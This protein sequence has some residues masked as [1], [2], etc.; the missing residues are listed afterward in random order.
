MIKKVK[1]LLFDLDGVLVTTERNHFE[2]WKSIADELSIPFDEY[3]NEQ[4]KGVSRVDSLKKILA[5]GSIE[6]TNSEFNRLLTQKNERYLLSISDLN[7]ENILPGV[8]PLLQNAKKHSVKLGVGSSSKNARFILEKLN[9]IHYFD[10]IVDGNDVQF[11]KPHPEVF[12][13]GANTLRIEPQEIMVFE[14]AQSGVQA[15]K[16]GGFFTVGVGNKHLEESTDL[17]FETLETFR[18]EEYAKFV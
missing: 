16:E 3:S 12:L 13:K 9:L 4:L 18:L 17:Y 8:K 15:A 5:M 1:G 14:D 7:D 10:V 2:A 6:L 11:P